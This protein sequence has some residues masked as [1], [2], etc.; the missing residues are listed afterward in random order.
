MF[1]NMALKDKSLDRAL[2]SAADE[3][4]DQAA[5]ILKETTAKD[6]TLA[7]DN[8]NDRKKQFYNVV[9]SNATA[10]V[11]PI[12]T[13]CWSLA[14]LLLILLVFFVAYSLLRMQSSNET[15]ET[16]MSGDKFKSIKA[17]KEQESQNTLTI[18]V[19]SL[20]VV[21]FL[22]FA[23][24][25]YLLYFKDTTQHE[26]DKRLVMV[27]TVMDQ[28]DCDRDAIDELT[29][30]LRV[31]MLAVRTL[32]AEIGDYTEQLDRL[33]K[34]DEKNQRKMEELKEQKAAKEA[35]AAKAKAETS[36]LKALYTK[37]ESSDLRN[38]S[39]SI[40]P[41]KNGTRKWFLMK[42]G[43]FSIKI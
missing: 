11:T 34:K 24:F 39:K 32:E 36:R 25:G 8:R 23:G 37:P 41:Q 4:S 26:G 10:P 14:A 33:N 31:Q 42:N 38:R 22:M 28:F 20:G 15:L 9:G 17:L 19:M 7:K 13:I 35:E 1:G 16:V 27:H 30:D 18:Y 29:S 12:V 3:S 5:W 21:A 2:Y 6:L 40:T 43:T